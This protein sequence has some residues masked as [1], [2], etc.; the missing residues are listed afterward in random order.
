MDG[1]T[2]PFPR[3]SRPFQS[4]F[5]PGQTSRIG[6]RW[7]AKWR[8]THR[9]D[10]WV[11]PVFEP[12]EFDHPGLVPGQIVSGRK[13]GQLGLMKKALISARFMLPH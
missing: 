7:I 3:A 1:R 4:P 2:S 8:L 11:G 6:T 9:C 12:T 13:G 5:P 10:G